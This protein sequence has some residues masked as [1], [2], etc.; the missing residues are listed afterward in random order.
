VYLLFI[1]IF[2]SSLTNAVGL[3]SSSLKVLMDFTP[4]MERT[5][6]YVFTTN[7]GR[8]MDYIISI[9]GGD[10]QYFHPSVEKFEQ[11]PSGEARAFTVEMKLP[12]KIDIPGL[13]ENL[14][15]V[16]E[17]EGRSGGGIG[18][19]VEICASISFRVLYNHKYIAIEQ[20]DT[21][22]ADRGDVAPLQITIKSWTNQDISKM[23]ASVDIFG[24]D[25]KGEDKK[26]TTVF[27]EEKSLPSNA[28]D[29]LTA[30]LDTKNFDSGEYK[31]YA[32]VV[33]DGSEANASSTFRVGLLTIKVINYTKLFEHGK[34][35][36]FDVQVESRWNKRIDNVFAEIFIEND[37]IKTPSSSLGPWQ[38]ITL[39]GYW[40]LTERRAGEYNGKMK[41][42]YGSN[43]TESDINV[44][45]IIG[46]AEIQ[47]LIIAAA[48][49]VVIL[50]LLLFIGFLFIKNRDKDEN[51][52]KS[53]SKK[54]PKK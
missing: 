49:S 24:S 4:N 30:Y 41:L 32:T 29:T 13:H 26:I 44:K 34:V 50:L 46:K 5:F 54:K 11:V 1:P 6:S 38:D 10:A 53:K 37:T 52:E 18:T 8:T 51:E 3:S 36:K 20:L 19:R 22:Y 17:A 47:K 42:Y 45:V 14:I 31:A 15:C 40:D 27:S 7:A 39:T 9:S 33:Y 25:E 16:T 12:E 2:L 23:Q 21:P 43:L 28:R 35:N 48:I